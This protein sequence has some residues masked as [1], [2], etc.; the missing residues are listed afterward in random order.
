MDKS[1]QN[2]LFDRVGKICVAQELIRDYPDTVRLMLSDVLIIDAITNFREG[3]VT[4]IGYSKHFDMVEEGHET[5]LYYA[6]GNLEGLIEF[7]RINKENGS[8]GVSTK[9]E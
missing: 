1:E 9:N 8:L 4:Y 3:V 6:Y 5:P 7:K 2:E